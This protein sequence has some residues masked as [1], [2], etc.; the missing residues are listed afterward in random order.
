MCDHPIYKGF[1]FLLLIERKFY[2][3][4]DTAVLYIEYP[5][6]DSQIK[7]KNNQFL[8]RAICTINQPHP[9]IYRGFQLLRTIYLSL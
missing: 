2:S 4:L 8:T 9:I 5:Y 3:F 7:D 6:I 1:R